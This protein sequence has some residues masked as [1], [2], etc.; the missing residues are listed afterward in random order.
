MLR[1]ASLLGSALA[2]LTVFSACS[3]VHS[4]VQVTDDTIGEFTLGELQVMVDGTFA[5]AYAAAKAAL[6]EQG[7]FLTGDER[8]VVEAVL[9][10]RDRA[11]T[12]ITVK[13]KEV[14]VGQTSVK[15]RYGLTGDA[16][17]SQA[18]FRTIARHL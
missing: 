9:T 15:I 14:A 13:L 10:A 5:D 3:S 2:G 8:K 17:R 6:E 18:L 16:A 1:R 4:T 11:D 12:Q 7:L